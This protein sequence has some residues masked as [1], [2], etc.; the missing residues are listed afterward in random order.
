MCNL[1]LYQVEY[2]TV[3]Q[4][5]NMYM[6]ANCII[7]IFTIIGEYR[8]YAFTY[9]KSSKTHIL[10]IYIYTMYLIVTLNYRVT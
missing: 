6:I 4:L 3:S 2:I 10:Y 5:N 9:S 1:S 7:Y 8:Y